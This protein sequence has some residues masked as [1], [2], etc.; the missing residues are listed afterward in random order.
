MGRAADASA[1]AS[2]LLD[3][4]IA[5]PGDFGQVCRD[6]STAGPYRRPNLG[7]FGT[8]VP[9]EYHP[10]KETIQ[11]LN[12]HRE[13]VIAEIGA[14]LEAL[15]W[16]HPPAAPVVPE[17]AKELQSEI[18]RKLP[19]DSAVPGPRHYE[20]SRMLGA[21][22]LRIIEDL[23][24]VEV[25]PHLLRLE[26]DLDRINEQALRV[27]GQVGAP[28]AVA[29]P[30]IEIGGELAWDELAFEHHELG[31][32][33]GR[34]R[35]Q[36]F[37]NLIFQREILGV[38]L[39]ML[40]R[41]QFAPLRESMVGRLHAIS[42]G[43]DRSGGS[44]PWRKVI[45]D[46]ARRVVT[47]FLRGETA[48]QSASVE[49]LLQFVRGGAASQSVSGEELFRTLI[50]QPGDWS[51]M[52][53]FPPPVA[54]PAPMPAEGQL[55][56]RHYNFGLDQ[57]AR[58]QAY[59][60]LVLPVLA[61]RL[62]SM[63]IAGS[64]V[65]A[66][67]DLGLPSDGSGQDGT[68]LSPLVLQMV[69]ALN[70][71]ECLPDLLR[72]EAELHEIIGRAGAD[73]KVA[74]PSLQLDSPS[75]WLGVSLAL[76]DGKIASESFEREQALHTC[77]I[78]QRE[79]LGVIQGGLL[80]QRFPAMENSR[81]VQRQRAMSTAALEEKIGAAKAASEIP[82][83][84]QPFVRWNLLTNRAEPYG[85][86][87]PRVEVPYDEGI[88]DEVRQIATQYLDSTPPDQRDGSRGM[89]LWWES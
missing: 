42:L 12:A 23:D 28:S 31:S 78:F 84:L 34:W 47:L 43:Q 25:L 16:E 59:R 9:Q 11:R 46:D 56:L 83:E 37:D 18:W 70:A 40:E 26:D 81:F 77:C 21:T 49:E 38:C 61:A 33:T 71:V 30:P 39:G 62:R 4:A 67:A 24:A 29:L 13:A 51:Q 64:A 41:R 44:L 2:S 48:P 53:A 73:P 27:E 76:K 89:D 65:P 79:L 80:Q 8:F 86:E 74:I 10:S 60:E 50:S 87:V 32:P 7:G 15:D 19:G 88:R 54:W 45:R 36:L 69:N 17:R 1:V 72:L 52:C 85:R 35:D 20:N 68:R 75:A 14:R 55:A 82:R 58:L 63:T 3:E 57:I 6:D 66:D 5:W 22:L